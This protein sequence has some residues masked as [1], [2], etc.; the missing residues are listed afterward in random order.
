LTK[1]S[2]ESQDLLLIIAINI[3]IVVIKPSNYFIIF[4]SFT[5]QQAVGGRGVV[6]GLIE[7]SLINAGRLLSS[8]QQPTKH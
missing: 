8:N 2:S 7:K 5:K 3:S 6:L 4:S 1:K